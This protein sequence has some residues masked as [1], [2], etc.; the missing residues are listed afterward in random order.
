MP[1]EQNAVGLAAHNPAAVN[2]IGKT[3]QD[4]FQQVVVLFRVVFQVSILDDEVLSGCFGNTGMQGG[5]FALVNFVGVE[6]NIQFGVCRSIALYGTGGIIGRI[7][8][9]DDDLFF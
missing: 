8:I 7:I 2:D 6:L 1:K 4:W 9:Y 5:S 3:G